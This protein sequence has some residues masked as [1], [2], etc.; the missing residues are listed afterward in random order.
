MFTAPA[1]ARQE[2]DRWPL[3]KAGLPARVV[4]SA[5]AAG[6][7]T[8]GNLRQRG[9][10]EW[11]SLHAVGRTSVAALQAY[12]QRCRDLQNGQL[13]F[14]N[15]TEALDSVLEGE[16]LDVLR[17]RYG[18]LREDGRIDRRYMTLQ[19]IGNQLHVTR[20]RIR[21]VEH[22]AFERLRGHMAQ[23]SLAPFYDYICAFLRRHH[24]IA[25]SAQIDQLNGQFWLDGYL[26]GPILLLLHDVNP[27]PYHWHNELF[28]LYPVATLEAI[29]DHALQILRQGDQ[30]VCTLDDLTAALQ[31]QVPTLKK[32]ALQRILHHH[33]DIIGTTD[34]RY[35]DWQCGAEVLLMEYV[36]P[37]TP[38]HFRTLTDILNRH[39]HP[40]SQ[41]GS[42]LLLRL[43][44]KSTRFQRMDRGLYAW[45]R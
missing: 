12:F 7:K 35:A 23:A 6:W 2:I 42:G 39:L 34:Q 10:V 18:F 33:A 20:E 29:G 26:A 3:E 32:L 8:V 5:T 14:F 43:L 25:D 31:K 44:N 36:P 28:S 41:R 27:T 19:E 38:E 16:S 21:Q 9:P 17:A 11:A 4:H 22:T 30:P 13:H 1:I 37:D 40:R 45:H 15:I 24:G